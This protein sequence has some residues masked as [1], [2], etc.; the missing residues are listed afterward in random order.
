MIRT[1]K[2]QHCA[3]CHR[4]EV[5]PTARSNEARW[6]Y[7]EAQRDGPAERE[8]EDQADLGADVLSKRDLAKNRTDE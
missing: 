1:R 4:S 8:A 3:R 6:S 5:N 7:Q 2:D